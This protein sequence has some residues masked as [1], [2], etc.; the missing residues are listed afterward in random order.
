MPPASRQFALQFA[1]VL[2]VL[3]LAWPYYGMRAEALPWGPTAAAIG[4]VAWLLATL[5]RQAWWWRLMH[6]LFAPLAWG[7]A[8]LNIDPGWF[9]ATFI[10]LL[11]IYRGALTGRIPLYLSNRPTARA[12]AEITAELGAVR[13]LDLGAG[14][15]SVIA[16]LARRQPAGRFEGLENAPL[17][18]LVGRIYTAALANCRLRYG[19]LWREDLGQWDVVYAF[20]SPEP[21]PELARKVV[22]EMAPE[23]LFISNSFPIPEAQPERIIEVGDT[24]MTRLYCYRP[25]TLVAVAGVV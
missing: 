25:A 22:A 7:V 6:A 8:Q 11:L 12:L 19:D 10:A 23:A 15:G 21:M 4:A 20:L 14:I 2:F 9:L 16:P 17:T 18:W 1:A 5:T 3:S 13:F 24:R